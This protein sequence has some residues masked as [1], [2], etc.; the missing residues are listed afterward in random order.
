MCPKCEGLLLIE[1]QKVEIININELKIGKGDFW[2]YHK[3]F[4]PN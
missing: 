2:K 4:P 3:F 1:P